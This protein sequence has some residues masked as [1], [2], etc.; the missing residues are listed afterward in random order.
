MEVLLETQRMTLRR[1]TASD[2]DN[3]LALDGDAEVMRF[4]DDGR[5]RTRE[6]IERD[7]VPAILAGYHHG[8]GCWAAIDRTNGIFLGWASLRWDRA[9]VFEL[10]YRMLR[11]TWGKGYATEAAKALVHKAFT[12]LGAE[13]VTATTMTVNAGSRRVMDKAG[14]RLVRTFFEEWPE[15]LEGAE[16]GDVEYALDRADWAQR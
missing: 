16:H 11:S 1:F 3:L 15:Y 13:R 10:G 2:V 8:G 6:R 12:E 14:L 5:V 4:L 7:T 9:G